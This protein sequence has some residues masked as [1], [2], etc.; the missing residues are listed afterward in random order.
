MRKLIIGVL[1]VLLLAGGAVYTGLANPLVEIQVRSALA[2]P[3]SA[4][5]A[6]PAWPSG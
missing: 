5:S 4:R 2:H 1:L 6:L 3:A